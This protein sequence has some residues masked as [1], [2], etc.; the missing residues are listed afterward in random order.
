MSGQ[1]CTENYTQ[2]IAT[3]SWAQSI[4]FTPICYTIFQTLMQ[5]TAVIMEQQ[6]YTVHVCD[7]LSFVNYVHSFTYICT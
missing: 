4:Y 2:L 3:N 5:F 7:P 1:N 6:T